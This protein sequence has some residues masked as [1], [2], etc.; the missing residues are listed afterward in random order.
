MSLAKGARMQGAQIF[1]DIEV[2][3]V[4]ETTGSDGLKKVAGVQTTCG[5]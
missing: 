2:D 5:T 4:L 1:S 3:R